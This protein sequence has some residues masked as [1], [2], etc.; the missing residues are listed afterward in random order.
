MQL[1]GLFSGGMPSRA[2]LMYGFRGTTPRVVKIPNSMASAE[3][4]ADVAKALD[5]AGAFDVAKKSHLVGPIQLIPFKPGST[6]EVSDECRS[7]RAG[8]V[9]PIYA[10]TLVGYKGPNAASGKAL[11]PK[12]API[13][14]VCPQ[15]WAHASWAIT[16]DQAVLWA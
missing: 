7:A 16:R 4:E 13:P 10:S 8:L 1:T 14:E 12:P 6:I 11:P 9:M 5:A 15:P 2:V 3:A